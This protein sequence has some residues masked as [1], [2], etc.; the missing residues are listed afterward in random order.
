[1]KSCSRTMKSS[2]G[3]D[4]I[5]GLRLQMKLNPPIRR[6]GGFHPN[7]VGFH[8]RSRFLPPVRVD[9][10]EKSTAKQCFFLVELRRIELLSEKT[11]IG[12]SS[13]VVGLLVLPRA[14]AE[15]QAAAFG[16]F[17]LCDRFKSKRAVHIYH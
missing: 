8:R 6:R 9:L 3:S 4:E 14:A 16:S 7:G 12:L 13:G 5:F 1:M 10:A 11:L 15:R 17:F 2:Q